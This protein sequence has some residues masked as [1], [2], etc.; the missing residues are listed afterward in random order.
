MIAVYAATFH[1]GV[2]C[3]IHG[4]VIFFQKRLDLLILWHRIYLH[5]MPSGAG[6]RSGG[7]RTTT[8]TDSKGHGL[9][10]RRT[11]QQLSRRVQT[12]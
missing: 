5:R 7:I 11:R 2:M 1:P 9:D 6:W 8:F 3:A 4:A 12:L 10:E